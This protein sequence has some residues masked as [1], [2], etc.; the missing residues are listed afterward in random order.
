[1][2]RVTKLR[3]RRRVRN[4]RRQVEGLSVTAEESFDKHFIRRL[5]RL[6]EVRRFVAGWLTLIILLAGIVIIQT[7]ALAGY[8]QTL[9]PV[10]GG[11][12]T[13]GVIGTL[14]NANPLFASSMVDTTVSKLLFA[15]LLN[16]DEH[17]NL[18]GDLAEKW[19]L[20]KTN[21]IY[22]VVLKPNLVWQDGSKLTADDVVFTYQ[23]AQNPDVKS[24]LFASWRE[25]S[26][27]K[28]DER[29]VTFTLKAPFAPFINSLLTGIIPMHL[30]QKVDPS[31]L[32]SVS[33]NTNKPVGAGPFMWQT[34][35]IT[36]NNTDAR[37]QHIGLIANPKYNGGRP[38]LDQFVIKA[39]L[40]KDR[41]L[42]AFNERR[43]DAAVGLDKLPDELKNSSV[44]AYETP[45]TAINMAFFLN[46]PPGPLSDKKVRTALVEAADTPA[47]IKSL[48]FPVIKSD[49]PVLKDSFAY[50]PAYKQAGKNID[51]A[52][53]LLDDAGWPKSNSGIRQKADKDLTLTLL[54]LNNYDNTVVAK[55][56]QQSW[57]SVGVKVNVVLQDDQDLQ[58]SVS[59]R[60]YD[61][62]LN[63]IS[64][65]TDPD[66]YAFWHS[67]QADKRS[68][69]RLNF[70][71]YTSET[72]DKALDGGRTR[73]EVP[74]RTAKYKPFLQAW[75]TDNPA[76]ALYQPR[77]LYVTRGKLFFYNPTTLNSST[78]RL[79]NVQNWMIRQSN[80]VIR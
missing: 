13:E 52:N 19:S 16:R 2:Y 71:D 39:F 70:S 12:Y 29:T 46:D 77:F 75:Q 45:L 7:R 65:G 10:P 25:V 24:P 5:L 27:A 34:L 40:T 60:S 11:I 79:N 43:I 20:D 51:Q 17:N 59:N 62:L 49:E 61:V 42:T 35:E 15:S 32:R 6:A 69:N 44:S 63:A 54:G 21:T 80:T 67:S 56:L 41:M 78:D 14:T 50:D 47:A 8:Y 58:S 22:T 30:L 55:S 3:W 73:V 53:H 76:L 57:A 48:G 64:M 31:Q 74:L 28:V 36:G 37:E 18:T 4:R 33:F 38:K 72:A 9:T 23:S 66:S 1:M 68:P 26:I